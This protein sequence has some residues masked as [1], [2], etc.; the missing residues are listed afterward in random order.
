MP[1]KLV[2][3]RATYDVLQETEEQYLVLQEPFGFVC[4]KRK[5]NNLL[6]GQMLNEIFDNVDLISVWVE[7][8]IDKAVKAIDQY[9]LDKPEPTVEVH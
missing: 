7:G 6:A 2:I 5:K 8:D 1:S 4:V 9:L 3:A